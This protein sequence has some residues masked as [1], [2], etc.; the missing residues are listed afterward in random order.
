MLLPRLFNDKFVDNVFDDMFSF[1]SFFSMP[2]NRWMSTNV[3]DMGNDYQ[4]EI[5]LPGYKKED[6][7][8]KLDNGYLTIA[9]DQQSDNEVKD[10]DGKYIRKESYSGKC[11]RSFYVGED[12]KEEDFKA[13]F[14]DGI[15]SVVFPKEKNQ[16]KIENQRYIPIE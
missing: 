9:A 15:L 12:L 14:K 10:E 11:Q 8:A 7:H 4:L 3:K 2:S 1:P 16:N 13:S 5:E 6:I